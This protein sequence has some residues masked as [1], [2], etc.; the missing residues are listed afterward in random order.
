[1]LAI[2]SFLERH[3]GFQNVII[4]ILQIHQAYVITVY[5]ILGI[6]VSLIFRE[7][8]NFLLIIDVSIIG[9]ISKK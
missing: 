1:M 3:V 9:L 2:Y 8:Q 5:I 7:T 4:L 6:F